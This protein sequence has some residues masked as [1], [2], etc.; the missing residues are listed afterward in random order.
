MSINERRVEA[1]HAKNR[2]EIAQKEKENKARPVNLRK[3]KDLENIVKL[4][5]KNK[6]KLHLAK[7]GVF[8]PTD[9][10]SHNFGVF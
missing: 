3:I 1:K 4:D 2:G 8:Q 9:V 5:R 7:L 10:C 6:R